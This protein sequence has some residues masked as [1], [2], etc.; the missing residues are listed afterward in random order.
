MPKLTRKA[1]LSVRNLPTEKRAIV[2]GSLSSRGYRHP[3]ATVIPR[4]PSSRGYRHPA[5]TVIPRLPSS[6]GYR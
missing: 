2:I 3:A 5:A 1:E 6:R 4:L